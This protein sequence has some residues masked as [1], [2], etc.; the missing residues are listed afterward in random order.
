M[1]RRYRHRLAV[2]AAAATTTIPDLATRPTPA[3]RAG[4]LPRPSP[5]TARERTPRAPRLI[6]RRAGRLPPYRR[7][8]ARRAPGAPGSVMSD[9]IEEPDGPGLLVPTALAGRYPRAPDVITGS[10]GE[11]H[12]PRHVL[13]DRRCRPASMHRRACRPRRSAPRPDPRC[14]RP[15]RAMSC[16]VR[17]RGARGTPSPALFARATRACNAN[18]PFPHLPSGRVT[19]CATGSVMQT[20]IIEVG[21]DRAAASGAVWLSPLRR[22]APVVPRRLPPP[23]ATRSPGK[24]SPWLLYARPLSRPCAPAGKPAPTRNGDPVS[25]TIVSRHSTN[26][27][28]TGPP[29]LL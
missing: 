12:S 18:A 13:R 22:F 27:A 9:G 15:L 8:P 6:T 29:S 25:A 19:L 16:R 14:R 3:L 10:V 2:A 17:E 5:P 26:D 28:H 23:P 7:E 11:E 20:V 4:G 1:G 21:T 24:L